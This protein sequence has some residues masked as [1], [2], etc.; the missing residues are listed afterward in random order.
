MT[1]KSMFERYAHFHPCYTERWQYNFT[2]HLK[3]TQLVSSASYE[4]VPIQL[5]TAC[6]DEHAEI[7]LLITCATYVSIIHLPL[8]HHQL[9][10]SVPPID[11]ASWKMAHV[12]SFHI[13]C[14]PSLPRLQNFVGNL[15]DI[16]HVCWHFGNRA[17]NIILWKYLILP[18]PTVQPIF[19]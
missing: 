9:P 11:T 18:Q 17:I 6:R 8:A 3:Q 5:S 10:A 4:K 19:A 15:K 12:W 14:L 7:N 1:A 13:Y 2:Q 16:K